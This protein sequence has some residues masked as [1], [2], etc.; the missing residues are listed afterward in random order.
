MPKTK[1]MKVRLGDCCMVCNKRKTEGLQVLNTFMCESCETELLQ[2]NEQDDM[3][4]TYVKQMRN[5][6]TNFIG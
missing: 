2:L 4:E 5:L 6:S 3:Y 1:T